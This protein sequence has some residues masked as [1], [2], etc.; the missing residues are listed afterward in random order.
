MRAT[1][2]PYARA[3]KFTTN[4]CIIARSDA[5]E[6]V[7]HGV[8]YGRAGDKTRSMRRRR[9]PRYIPRYYYFRPLHVHERVRACNATGLTNNAFFA[10][11]PPPSR[12]PALSFTPSYSPFRP[13]Y[14]SLFFFS[15][16]PRRADAT[17][18]PTAVTN[19]LESGVN[20]LQVDR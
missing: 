6:F 4:M 11:P 16:Y 19:S 15:W 9:T 20:Q 18:R 2:A 14:L 13:P 8:I 17:H 7:K 3:C 12:P 1:F 5:L 10:V